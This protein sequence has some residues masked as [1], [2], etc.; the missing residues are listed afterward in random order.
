MTVTRLRARGMD[1]NVVQLFFSVSNTSIVPTTSTGPPAVRPSESS[2]PT[3]IFAHSGERAPQRRH[4]RQRRPT[5]CFAVVNPNLVF[6]IPA[7]PSRIGEAETAEHIEFLADPDRSPVVEG[8]GLAFNWFQ[9]SA[10]GS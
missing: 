3:G 1:F 9:V 6:G 4:R 5:L 8:T 10:L 2:M 7:D